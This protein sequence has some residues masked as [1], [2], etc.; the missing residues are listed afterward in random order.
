MKKSDLG[1]LISLSGLDG[2]GKSTQALN[3]KKYLESKEFSANVIHLKTIPSKK[4][5]AKVKKRF[6]DYILTHHIDGKEEAHQICCAFLY[7]EKVYDVVG[8]SLFTYDYTI[9]DR[10]RDSALC[11]QYL[12][13]Q[14][15]QST[16]DIYDLLIEPSINIF[17]DYPPK[18][19][20][21]R[22]KK[23]KALSI[24]ETPEYLKKAYGYYCQN[25]NRFIWIDGMQESKKV[26]KDIMEF[27]SFE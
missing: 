27:F 18:D 21:T 6:E 24:F 23:R 8:Q 7:F 22:L 9:M 13:D 19:C 16:S 11:N 10:Y 4:Y 15:Y 3:I 1:Y 2:S 25:K 26:T 5:L 20:Y 12:L 17:I 14:V